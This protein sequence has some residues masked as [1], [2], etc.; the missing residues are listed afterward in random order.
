M[1]MDDN[2]FFQVLPVYFGEIA[3]NRFIV[4]SSL[5]KS[6]DIFLPVLCEKEAI[7][8]VALIS[9][10]ET[11]KQTNN[12]SHIF[13]SLLFLSNDCTIRSGKLVSWYLLTPIMP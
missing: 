5:K 3:E 10:T 13:R 4:C 8:S 12:E 1:E 2:Q 6:V 9:F 7:L 11:N